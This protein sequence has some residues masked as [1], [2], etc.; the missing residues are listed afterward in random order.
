MDT[1]FGKAVGK[2]CIKGYAL[3][4]TFSIFFVWLNYILK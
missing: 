4:N 3:L 2:A 1:L